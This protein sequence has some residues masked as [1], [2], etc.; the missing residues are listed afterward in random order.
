MLFCSCVCMFR[1]TNLFL[2]SRYWFFYN[3]TTTTFFFFF[4]VTV[5]SP[6]RNK[7]QHNYE[8][9]NLA[10]V[11]FRKWGSYYKRS[12][13]KHETLTMAKINNMKAR[14][15]RLRVITVTTCLH[16]LQDA[17][18]NLLTSFSF[19]WVQ[20]TVRILLS[21]TTLISVRRPRCGISTVCCS[22]VVLCVEIYANTDHWRLE[23]LQY[24]KERIWLNHALAANRL[25]SVR[26]YLIKVT[27]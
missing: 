8:N 24:G 10:D 20:V 1:V 2:Y 5:S 13:N 23:P 21:I 25:T 12:E 17:L 6:R 27:I 7:T 14:T 3:T 4:Y 11:V 19:F 16:L 22:V 26:S 15:Q 18:T 9:M